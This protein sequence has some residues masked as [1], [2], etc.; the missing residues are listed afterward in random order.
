MFQQDSTFN[1]HTQYIATLQVKIRSL[2]SRMIPFY[3]HISA[4]AGV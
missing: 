3:G 4:N 2:E 1:V